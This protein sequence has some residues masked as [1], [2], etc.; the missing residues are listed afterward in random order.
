[1]NVFGWLSGRFSNR[2]KAMWLYKRGMKKA[3]QHNHQGAI[4]DY[5]TTIGML[6]TPND[7]KA[8]ALYNRALVHVASGED[9]KGV[10]DLD[11]VLL[12]KEMLVNVK[13]MARE[14]LMRMASRAK[15]NTA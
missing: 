9:Q 13:T 2:G 11:A 4:D 7:V 1:M 6:E 3:K 14:K 10:D 12:M 5:T 15:K 8:M